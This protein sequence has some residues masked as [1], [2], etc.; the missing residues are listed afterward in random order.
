MIATGFPSISSVSRAM[1]VFAVD[2]LKRKKDRL[3]LTQVKYSYIAKVETL[4]E[5]WKKIKTK[6]F[7]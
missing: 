6:V 1:Y 4:A 3:T 7:Y 5:D 2:L